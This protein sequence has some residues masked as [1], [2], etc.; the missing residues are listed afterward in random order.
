MP[1]DTFRIISV[2]TIQERNLINSIA[3]GRFIPIGNQIVESTQLDL[4]LVGIQ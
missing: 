1:R 4:H 3:N 2:G